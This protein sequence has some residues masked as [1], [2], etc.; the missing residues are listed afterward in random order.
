MTA[1]ASSRHMPVLYYHI[2]FIR[3]TNRFNDLEGGKP[4]PVG[5]Y[6]VLLM[7]RLLSII[8]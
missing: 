5:G 4:G 3:Y 2:K 1:M 8:G 6:L 7:F